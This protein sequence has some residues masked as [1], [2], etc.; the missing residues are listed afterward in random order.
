M[1][2][3]PGAAGQASCHGTVCLRPIQSLGTGMNRVLVIGATSASAEAAMRLLA[4]SNARLYLLARDAERMSALVSD[5]LVRGAEFAQYHVLDVNQFDQHQAALD[6]AV[7]ALGGIDTVLVAHG[8][9]S[10]QAACERDT[11]LTLQEINT[12]AVSTILL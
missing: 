4:A 5:L 1:A 2:G 8:T 9:L 11:A 12:N 7:K 10:N 3:V 6:V